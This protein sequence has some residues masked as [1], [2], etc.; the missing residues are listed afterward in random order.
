MEFYNVSRAYRTPAYA[1]VPYDLMD[2]MPERGGKQI[3]CVYLWLHRFGWGSEEGC[4]A[5]R[6]TIA[7]RTGI[8]VQDVVKA[9]HWLTEEGWVLR[10]PRPGRTAVYTV[11]LHREE[12]GAKRDRGAKKDPLKTGEGGAKRYLG[13]PVPKSTP[14]KNPAN[15]NPI[16][17]FVDFPPELGSAAGVDSG[18]QPRE[19]V[20]KN[21]PPKKR[22]R[23]PKGSV[24][25][26]PEFEQFWRQYQSISKRASGQSKP[27]A[28]EQYR[29]AL[30]KCP[31]EALQGALTAAVQEQG[32]MERKGGFV[33]YFPDCFRWLRDGKYETFLGSTDLLSTEGVA[34]SKPWENGAPEGMPF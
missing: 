31:S 4:W 30:R 13:T 12:G 33:A 26:S 23:K 18:N 32:A 28:W 7:D 17:P 3:I 19:Q 22:G 24:P 15:K 6:A 10:T 1:S 25:Y 21:E 2:L 8:K 27:L 11:R 14:N 20:E 16:K 29:K 9:L 34:P 5:S